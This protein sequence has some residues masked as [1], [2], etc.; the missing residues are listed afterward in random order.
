LICF[1]TGLP[2]KASIGTAD[3]L[4]IKTIPDVAKMTLHGLRLAS[5]L[6]LAD[7]A[8]YPR[9][10]RRSSLTPLAPWIGGHPCSGI[11]G[12]IRQNN[13][14]DFLGLGVYEDVSRLSVIEGHDGEMSGSTLMLAFLSR[15][16]VTCS[17]RRSVQAG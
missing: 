14:R 8:C 3:R 13:L 10:S 4:R 2:S 15:I 9:T 6:Q 1:H 7:E 5:D 12:G 17:R 11:E 16:E